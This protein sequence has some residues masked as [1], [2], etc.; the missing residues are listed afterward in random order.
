MREP[1]ITFLDE[2]AFRTNQALCY[3]AYARIK[4]HGEPTRLMR[5][6][7]NRDTYDL[8]SYAVVE[9][10]MGNQGWMEAYRLVDIRRLN[11]SEFTYVTKDT[12]WPDF[13]K[14]DATGLIHQWIGFW[15]TT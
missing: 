1:E 4:E 2:Q 7:I 10:W 9:W 14:I 12:S 13:A 3:I 15:E 5:V 8:Q 6:R 11:I